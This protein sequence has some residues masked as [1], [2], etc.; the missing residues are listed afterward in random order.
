MK[1]KPKVQEVDVNNEEKV[2]AQEVEASNEEKIKIDKEIEDEE[3]KDIEEEKEKD[4][5]MEEHNDIGVKQKEAEIHKDDTETVPTN[6]GAIKDEG[7]ILIEPMQQDDTETCEETPHLL[8][9]T[10][11]TAKTVPK[12]YSSALGSIWHWGENSDD[13]IWDVN[14]PTTGDVE[15]SVDL[16]DIQTEK[17]FSFTAAVGAD[18]LECACNVNDN[19]YMTFPLESGH[20]DEKI[21][22]MTAGTI[23]ITEPGAKI[24][25]VKVDEM[26]G[27]YV[28]NLRQLGLKGAGVESAVIQS[29]KA[30]TVSATW[31]VKECEIFYSGI[32]ISDSSP[33]TF[34]GVCCFRVLQLGLYDCQGHRSVWFQINQLFEDQQEQSFEILEV[35]E[36]VK[37]TDR[38]MEESK[39]IDG[40]FQFPWNFDTRYNVMVKMEEVDNAFKYSVYFYKEIEEV[41]KRVVVFK[42][43]TSELESVFRAL[44]E[45][46]RMG[47]V[48]AV[49]KA[50]FGPSWYYKENVWHQVE[51]V[52]PHLV[53]HVVNTSLSSN[54]DKICL[55]IAPNPVY[56]KDLYDSKKLSVEKSVPSVLD[57]F[58]NEV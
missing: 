28:G 11:I 31:D 45:D 38:R 33:G 4:K 58:L 43:A 56:Q 18:Q 49:K 9:L 22:R 40:V 2:E 23:N 6:F 44:I 36:D 12:N 48:K 50:K 47:T 21:T 41:W 25:V 15:I 42:T 30:N 35:G 37:V 34:F 55:L 39:T 14:F 27:E 54:E 3:A 32:E 53:G 52:L 7:T 57:Q 46:R 16:H 5:E 51:T 13:L 20:D 8:R 24:V 19:Y 17:C 1:K 26:S 29:R 10:P